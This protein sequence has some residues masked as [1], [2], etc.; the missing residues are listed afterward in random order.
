[1]IEAVYIGSTG[2]GLILLAFVL[3]QLHKWKDTYFIYDFVNLVGS[4]L[5]IWYAILL[6]S[7]PFLVLN[8]VWALVSLRDVVTDLRRN[9]RKVKA[10]GSWDKWMR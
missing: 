3:G 4:V 6:S 2:A 1:M 7:W 5:L 9:S 8:G 10:M